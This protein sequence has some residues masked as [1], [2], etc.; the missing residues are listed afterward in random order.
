MARHLTLWRETIASWALFGMF[1]AL[2]TGASLVL[3]PAHQVSR[4]V[5]AASQPTHLASK[6]RIEQ[7]C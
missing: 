3:S 4:A 6:V 2:L 5:A 1:L 7:Q